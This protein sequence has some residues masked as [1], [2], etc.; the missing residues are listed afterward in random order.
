[1]KRQ[2]F[3]TRS[4]AVIATCLVPIKAFAFGEEKTYV[5]F[6]GDG[7]DVIMAKGYTPE[8]AAGKFIDNDDSIGKGYWEDYCRDMEREQEQ[9][10]TWEEFRQQEIKG[11]VAESNGMVFQEIKTIL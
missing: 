5:F 9:S 1:M 2:Q 11:M 3:I 8:E 7:G 6:W 4:L 10:P